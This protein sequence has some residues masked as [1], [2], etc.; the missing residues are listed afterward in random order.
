MYPFSRVDEQ[1]R[2]VAEIQRLNERCPALSGASDHRA[3]AASTFLKL[4]REQKESE[5]AGLRVRCA[6]R[7]AA[8]PAMAYTARRCQELERGS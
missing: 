8:Q 3:R 7:D 4:L 2:L 5:L 6:Q 1:S